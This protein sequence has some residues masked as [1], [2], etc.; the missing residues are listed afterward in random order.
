M[1]LS[2][3]ERERIW[4]EEKVRAEARDETEEQKKKK[5]DAKN[6]GIGCLS[7]II[8]ALGMGTCIALVGSDDGPTYAGGLSGCAKFQRMLPEWTLGVLTD[9]EIRDQV[10]EI[11]DRTSTAEPAISL[12]SAN[13]L[14]GITQGDTE[15]FLSGVEEL[16]D[17][18]IEK[19]YIQPR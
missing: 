7:V 12:A 11:W 5:K 13:M 19:G 14:R 17:A 16:A 15:A 2:D 10:K 9:A 3:E 6:L 1:A 4:E 8:L 18:C